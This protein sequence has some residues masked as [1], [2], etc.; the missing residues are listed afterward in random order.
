[1]IQT[2]LHLSRH[3]SAAFQVHVSHQFDRAA[4]M[5]C[6]LLGAHAAASIRFDAIRRRHQKTPVHL[7]HH[8]IHACRHRT[9][10]HSLALDHQS[11]QSFR[12]RLPKRVRLGAFEKH[13]R[14]HLAP[15]TN[16]PAS[17]KLGAHFPS[18]NSVNGLRAPLDIN[19]N[20]GRCRRLAAQPR[21]TPDSIRT[22]PRRGALTL[23]PAGALGDAPE[24][25]DFDVQLHRLFAG[26]WRDSDGPRITIIVRR[27]GSAR[28]RS[29]Y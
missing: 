28:Y 3:G 5:L 4:D 18:R 22:A 15:E 6:R 24:S 20:T 21:I 10:A 29:L 9:P 8:R 11:A 27:S 23:V 25:G 19:A 2:A 13:V 16:R 26:L 7:K 12:E 17:I 1:M 14:R